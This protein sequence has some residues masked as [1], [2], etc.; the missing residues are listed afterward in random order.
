VKGPDNDGAG[1]SD[2]EARACTLS[3]V[4]PTRNEALNVGSLTARLQA[5][6]S[7]TRGGWELIFVDDSD[8]ATPEV[9][10][11]LAG[12]GVVGEVGAGKVGPGEVVARDRVVGKVGAS[13]AVAGQVG[14]GEAGVSSAVRLLHRPKGMRS[15]GLGGAVSE[16]FAIATGRVVVVM[17]ADLQHPPEILPA[18][19]APVLSGEADL[20]A[21]SRYGWAGADAGLS[22]RWRHLVSGGCRWLVHLLVPDSRPLQD[23]LSGLFALRRSLLDGVE[24]RPAG[25]K[26]LLEVTVRARPALVGNV[27]FNFGPRHAGRS[28][29]NLREGAVFFR[30]LARLV[31]ANRGGQAGRAAR[32]AVE[33]IG[34]VDLRAKPLLEPVEKR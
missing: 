19:I 28:K 24:L 10:R 2:V 21:G 12:E 4:V 3:V 8:D 31:G 30:H 32:P 25:Y 33:D 6:L 34:S 20:V 27:G 15:G 23:P 26:I 17:D 5:A 18:L 16:G 14:P 9:V 29:A 13:E 1:Y 7:R 22:S 11:R